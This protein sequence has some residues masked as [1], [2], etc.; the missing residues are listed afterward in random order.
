M[1]DD[2]TSFGGLSASWALSLRAANKA[3]KTIE[4]YLLCARL[5]DEF[6][7]K[8]VTD[9]RKADVEAF[10]ADQLARW[11]PSTALVRFKSLQQFFRWLL[12]EEEIES[13][14]MAGISPPTVPDSPVPII[15]DSMLKELLVSC[16][17]KG[18]EDRRDT[19]I[20]RLFIETPC[21]LS[22]IALLKTESVDLRESLIRIIAK[23]GRERL[24]PF[25]PKAATAVDRYLRVRGRHRY[26][27]MAG[28]WL[29]PSG[30]MTSSGLD[31][32]LKRRCSR[33]DLPALHWHQF[34][35]TFAHTWKAGGSSDDDLMSL[36]G[37]K[38]RAMLGKYA[39]ST[40]DER[41][42][43][44]YNRIQPGDRI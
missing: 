36:A 18:F 13:N 21:R 5:L 34:R 22:E 15:R 9:V 4:S 44:A 35:H 41:A 38:S 17:G 31:Q 25:G 40:A 8:P 20:F 7:Q 6:V 42:R 27:A 33:A 37:W 26:A 11:K 14:P 3:E 32:M 39:A 29:G 1:K 19:A 10:I 43:A 24:I 30:P 28:L 16:G 12:A 2:P 23:G